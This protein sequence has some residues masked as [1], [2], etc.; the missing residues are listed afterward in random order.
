M[1]LFLLNTLFS[2]ARVRH[3]LTHS[4]CESV[5]GAITVLDKSVYS[6]FGTFFFF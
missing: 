4:T 3:N 5:T 2:V 6:D 1:M